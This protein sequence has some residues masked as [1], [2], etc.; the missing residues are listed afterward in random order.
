MAENDD[1]QEKTEEP[2]QRRLDKALEDG[3]ILTSKEMFV[4]T[5]M[6]T[7]IVLLFGLGTM[8]PSLLH[9]WQGYFR[10][11]TDDSVFHLSHLYLQDVILF[12]V[13]VNLFLQKHNPIVR[14]KNLLLRVLPDIFGSR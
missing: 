4:F 6:F 12:S 3:Q 9:K 8:M 11:E 2:S 14:I 13:P 1:S 5:S 7:G 10:F